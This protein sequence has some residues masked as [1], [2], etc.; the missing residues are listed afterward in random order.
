MSPTQPP[1]PLDPKIEK[2]LEPE[3]VDFY[4]KY[5][6]NQQVVH[7][8]PVEASR[9]SGILIPGGSDPLP[10]ES[11]KDYKVER[12]ESEGNPLNVRV[13]TP[14]IAKPAAGL[15][16]FIYFH[17][18]GWVLGNINTENSHC[19]NWA[20]RGECVV[21]SVD[22]RLAPEHPYPAAVDDA[23]EAYLWLI[24][25]GANIIGGDI[26]KVGAGGSS[27][28][29]NLTA[30]LTHM[31]TERQESIPSMNQLCFQLLIVPVTD[32]TADK[33]VYWTWDKFENTAALSREKMLWYRYKYL[34]DEST[35]ADPRA[36]PLYFPETSFKKCPPAY[37]AVAELDVLR[38]EGVFYG[39][40]LARSGVPVTIKVYKGVPHVVM[41]MDGVLARGKELV[42][43]CSKAIYDAFHRK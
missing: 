7:H 25:E 18:G 42:S 40:K 12:K 13:F 6:I 35:W 36:S 23:W 27:A 5:I 33:D 2:L 38:A 31:I 3:Y 21:V 26:S 37:I 4:N 11:I 43:D 30:I 28:G 32:N 16:I 15:P 19:T 41:A 17:G 14:A 29:G 34:P 1:Y 10:M 20:L 24:R 9:T 39:E 22:Y 8:Q